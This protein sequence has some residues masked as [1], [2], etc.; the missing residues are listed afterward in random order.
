M[1]QDND[2]WSEYSKA[3]RDVLPK[4][5][6]FRDLHSK[7]IELCQPYQ[8]ILD[9][10]CGPGLYFEALLEQ[11]K[12]VYGIDFNE[13]MIEVLKKTLSQ[14]YSTDKIERC[15][16][17]GSILKLPYDTDFF[18]AVVNINVLYAVP[19]PLMALRELRRVTKNKGALIIAGPKP[20]SAFNRD[21]LKKQIAIDAQAHKDDTE[22]LEKVAFVVK[23]NEE[24]LDKHV[25]TEF[26]LERITN[27]ILE[28]GYSRIIHSD[29]TVYLGQ[30][31]LLK[32]EK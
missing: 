26:D 3:Y 32:A 6:F 31:W 8:K 16:R 27:M 18:D 17:R 1:N 9:A 2:I 11:G 4:L 19:N 29:D 7:V 5:S 25:E 23:V 14:K 24:I 10:G 30:S 21:L 22:F 12:D 20:T 15:V 28:A 13:N